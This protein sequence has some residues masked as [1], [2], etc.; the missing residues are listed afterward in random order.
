MTTTP[1][2]VVPTASSHQKILAADGRGHIGGVLPVPR[3]LASFAF[4]RLILRS[5]TEMWIYNRPVGRVISSNP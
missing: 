3:S 4:D 2:H 1:G 5:A